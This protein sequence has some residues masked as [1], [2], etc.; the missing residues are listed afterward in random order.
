MALLLA[1][2]L[3]AQ[4]AK[5]YS[6][7]YKSNKDYI[8]KNSKWSTDFDAMALKTVLKLLLSKYGILSVEMQTA[9]A[10][11]QGTIRNGVID[12]GTVQGNVLCRLQY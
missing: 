2:V 9:I 7:T 6:Q 12:S 11:D 10:A 4:Y 5:R 1:L 8:V 3:G